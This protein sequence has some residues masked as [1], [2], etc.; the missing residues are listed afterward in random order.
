[1]H[2]IIV[3]PASAGGGYWNMDLPRQWKEAASKL[4]DWFSLKLKGTNENTQNPGRDSFL[5][6]RP[7]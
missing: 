2:M 1:M 4:A 7:H 6:L 3:N 5:D